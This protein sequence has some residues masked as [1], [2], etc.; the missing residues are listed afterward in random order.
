M[1]PPL[2]KMN[3]FGESGNLLKRVKK[4]EEGTIRK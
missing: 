4:F 2:L 1:N 3:E